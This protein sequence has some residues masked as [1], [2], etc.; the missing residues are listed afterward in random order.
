MTNASIETPKGIVYT[1]YSFKGGVGRTMALADIAAL[2]AKWGRSVLVVDWDLE[3]PGVERFF[4]ESNSEAQ[5]VRATRP[6]VLDLVMAKAQ[7]RSLD[8]RDCV[9]EFR[10]NGDPSPVK[11]IT[12]GRSGPEYIDNLHA[13]N[14]PELFSKDEL[15]S[16][17]EELRNDWISDFEFVLIDSRTGVTD[18]GGICTVHLADVLVLLFTATYA[19]TDGV[20]EIFDRARKA[21]ERLPVDRGRLIAVPVPARDESRTEYEKAAEWKRIFADRFKDLYEDWLPT[22]ISVQDAIEQLKIP[23]F[24]YWSFGEKLPIR[25]GT[26]DPASLGRAYEILARL[27]ASRLNWDE[28]L[29]GRPYLPAQLRNA[30]NLMLSG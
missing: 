6:G 11:L 27:L 14:F 20:L 22:G 10:L 7:G 21:R 3:A 30:D 18:I 28:A 24:P 29:R 4:A 13:L 17:I 9:H 26:N 15:G 2:L 16:Y 5:R 8:W 1:F 25:D 23:Y 19:S 12:A